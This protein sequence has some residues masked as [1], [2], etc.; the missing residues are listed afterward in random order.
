MPARKNEAMTEE[1]PGT[2]LNPIDLEAVRWVLLMESR[3]LSSEQKRQLDAW[4]AQDSRHQGAFV[5][6]RAASLHLDRLAAFAA[7]GG[8]VDARRDEVRLTRRR[9]M[10]VAAAAA[11]IGAVGLGGWLGREP[12]LD[13]W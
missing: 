12:I 9:L 1:E 10:V 4:L 7:G 13:A 11:V 3:P 6:A 5:R 2:E 8:V